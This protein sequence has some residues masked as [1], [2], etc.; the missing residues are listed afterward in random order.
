M[1][2]KVFY[3]QHGYLGPKNC[4]TDRCP[5]TSS[6]GSFAAPANV[7]KLAACTAHSLWDCG[8]AIE[9]SAAWMRSGLRV[10][11]L[12]PW[13]LILRDLDNL[14]TNLTILTQDL[15]DSCSKFLLE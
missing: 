6:S 12:V 5:G 14:S 15:L 8:V 4:C 9:V 11:D 2:N 1:S 7:A 10:F 13:P 3:N